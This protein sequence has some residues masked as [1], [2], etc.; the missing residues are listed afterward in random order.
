[1]K[2]ETMDIKQLI[3]LGIDYYP[4]NDGGIWYKDPTSG[5]TIHIY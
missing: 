4:D 3:K 5:E 1:M 2:K